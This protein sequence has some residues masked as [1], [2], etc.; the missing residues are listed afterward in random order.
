MPAT[1]K[2]ERVV[3]EEKSKRQA[4]AE[5][6][7]AAAAELTRRWGYQKTTI[8]DIARQAGVA[9]GTIY[10]HWK[11]REDLFIAMLIHEQMKMAEAL[12]ADIFND[13]EGITL[14]GLLRH[15]LIALEEY[16]L[17]KAVLLM[18]SNMLGDLLTT[19]PFV[20]SLAQQKLAF[21]ENY[22][23][24]LRDNGLLRTDSEIQAQIYDFS[25][26]ITG[27]MLVDRF[28]PKP[29]HRSAGEVAEMASNAVKLLL[30]PAEPVPLALLTQVKQDFQE[31]LEAFLAATRQRA[32]EELDY[33]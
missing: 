29:L 10:L 20:S 6:I 19:S 8:D 5:R 30:E 27:Y 24:Y 17:I 23:Q 9:K 22:F 31:K 1:R 18:D 14:H 4:R 12:V 21:F 26:I 3:I 32:K 11:T 2:R 15:S 25:A 7:L 28:F 16:P 33:E 13:P